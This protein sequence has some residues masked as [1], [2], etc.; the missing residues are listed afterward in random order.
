MKRRS[1]AYIAVLVFT[2]T[3]LRPISS[4]ALDVCAASVLEP[5]AYLPLI[6]SPPMPVAILSA[7]WVNVYGSGDWLTLAV[8]GE[9]QNNTGSPIQN[10]KIEGVSSAGI[11]SSAYTDANLISAG[12]TA[13]FMI[14]FR[15]ANHGFV[16]CDRLHWDQL[17]VTSF[18]PASGPA[19]DLPVTNMT[20]GEISGTYRAAGTVTN[21]Y[22]WPILFGQAF[23][24]LYN[25][26]GQLIGRGHSY[27]D[28]VS[29]DSGAQGAFEVSVYEWK[30][31]PGGNHEVAS[32]E[33]DVQGW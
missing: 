14:T 12:G 3:A 26:D 19:I 32:Y 2:L 11:A 33:L 20:A 24:R 25:S 7:N 17:R 1:L 16:A 15:I 8:V 23:L 9:V 10:V 4:P 27:I 6:E 29:L 28:P 13:G 5:M 30:G 21:S 31:C 18:A 22:G